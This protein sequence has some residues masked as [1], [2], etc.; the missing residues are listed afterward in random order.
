MAK[1]LYGSGMR[2]MDVVRLRVEDADFDNNL[3][4]VCDGKGNKDRSTL[5]SEPLQAQLKQHLEGVKAV[6]DDD[7]SGGNG[8]VYLPTALAVN[9]PMLHYV[10]AG[11]MFFLQAACPGIRAAAKYGGITSM[12]QHCRKP[13]RRHATK[14][15]S[16]NASLVIVFA[17][18]SQPTVWR[19]V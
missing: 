7:L 12:I 16:R 1:M 11:S 10:E 3:I 2:L 4:V 17:T 5:F 19:T 13:F 8:Y 18:H 6:H 9:F 14:P 15:G